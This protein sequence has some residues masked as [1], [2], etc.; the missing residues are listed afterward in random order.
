MWFLSSLTLLVIHLRMHLQCLHYSGLFIYI[1]RYCFAENPTVRVQAASR[2]IET[3][4][5][6]ITSGQIANSWR[7]SVASRDDVTPVRLRLLHTS[8]QSCLFETSEK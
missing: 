1:V 6:F 3:I 5:Q 8:S 7:R 4:V 2:G